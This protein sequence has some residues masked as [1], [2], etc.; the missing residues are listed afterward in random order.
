MGASGEPPSVAKRWPPYWLSYE[1]ASWVDLEP[2][3]R[4]LCPRA[5]H[6]NPLPFWKSF[7]GGQLGWS[8][9]SYRA[10]VFP[11]PV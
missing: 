5:P 4:P 1:I 10:N 3:W 6:L 7:C 2:S 9:P 11:E 8:L